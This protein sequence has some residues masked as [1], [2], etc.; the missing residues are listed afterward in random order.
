MR[1]NH[2]GN[3]VE[4][5]LSDELGLCTIDVIKIDVEMHEPEVIA[6]ATEC[7]YQNHTAM[8][9]EIL[10]NEIGDRM[11]SAVTL[12]FFYEIDERLMKTRAAGTNA[13]WNYLVQ[14]QD[15][16]RVAHLGDATNIATVRSWI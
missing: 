4:I 10:D 7:L 14:S 6:G 15:D 16:P 3:Q 11:A 9:I 13:D 8:L 1:V 12:Y 2:F 5:D